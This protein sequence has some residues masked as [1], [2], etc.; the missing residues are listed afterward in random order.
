MNGFMFNRIVK[1][2]SKIISTKLTQIVF[3]KDTY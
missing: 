3:N 1:K 2:S